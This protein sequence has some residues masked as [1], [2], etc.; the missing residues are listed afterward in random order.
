MAPYGSA[1]DSERPIKDSA[2]SMQDSDRKSLPMSS[3]SGGLRS[4]SSNHRSGSGGIRGIM[5]NLSTHQDVSGQ[6]RFLHCLNLK[7][8]RWTPKLR[9]LQS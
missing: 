2:Q 4:A 7:L 3:G 9:Q 5:E 8:S 6:A 1:Q